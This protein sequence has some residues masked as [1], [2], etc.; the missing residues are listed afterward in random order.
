MPTLQIEGSTS[1]APVIC[2][3]KGGW[4]QRLAEQVTLH[5]FF[6]GR[7]IHLSGADGRVLLTGT[8]GSYYEKQLA[9]ELVRRFDGVKQID[10]RIQ[11]R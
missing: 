10:N 8:V 5:Q 11:V 3:E 7:S 2:R 1:S 4:E 6:R 9:Q